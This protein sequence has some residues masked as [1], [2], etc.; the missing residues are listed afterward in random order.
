MRENGGIWSAASTITG[1]A[2]RCS[3]R[4]LREQLVLVRDAEHPREPDDRR[5]RGLDRIRRI[6]DAHAAAALMDAVDVL[7]VV[8]RVGAGQGV[9]AGERSTPRSPAPARNGGGSNAAARESAPAI[10]AATATMIPAALPAATAAPS[11]RVSSRELGADH[12]VQPLDL[13]VDRAGEVHRRAHLG[14]APHLAESRL[15]AA[16]ID[17]GGNPEPERVGH[18]TAVLRWRSR[19]AAAFTRL[20]HLPLSQKFLDRLRELS[21]ITREQ[22][23]ARQTLRRSPSPD[24]SMI[25]ERHPAVRDQMLL[26]CGERREEMQMQAEAVVVGEAGIDPCARRAAS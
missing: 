26:E 20:P 21:T 10:T 12:I 4:E 9:R 17:D 14:R 24:E 5:I 16:R 7:V 13:D 22:S 18:R 1:T 6:H 23:G 3:G 8:D 2:C 11:L 19:Y 15:R 25:G